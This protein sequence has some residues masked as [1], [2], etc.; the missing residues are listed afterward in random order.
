LERLSAAYHISTMAIAKP[1][2]LELVEIDDWN[3]CGAT[4]YTSLNLIAAY[5]LIARNL[6]LATKSNGFK[7]IVA[8]CSSCYLNL[9]KTDKY[10]GEN[11]D[12][13]KKVN[14][15]LSAGKLAY[16]PG[17]IKVQHLLDVV[18]E[19]VGLETIQAKVTRPLQGLRLAPYYGC[20]IARPGFRPVSKTDVTEYPVT[21]DKLL[22]ALGAEV[23]DFP[24][25]THCCGGHMTQISE[26]TAFDLIRRIIKGAA[27]Y[28]ADIIVALCPMCQFNLDGFQGAM[29]AYFKTSYKIPVLYFTQMMGLAFGI[30][31]SDL[32]IGTE[33]VDARPALSKIG[34]NVPAPEEGKKKKAPKEALPMPR[35]PEER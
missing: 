3:C 8:P 15:A 31:A 28:Q 7:K 11:Q 32:G 34:V 14:E 5:S 16:K 13:N 35:M 27:D 9:L 23:I 6:A 18:M 2:G 25:K 29:N 30:D 26:Q 17:S 33:L 19:D 20:M 4:E 24:M 22:K 1:L 21:M 10:M 12:L